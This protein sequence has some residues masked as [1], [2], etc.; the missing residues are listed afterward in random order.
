ML[1]VINKPL[2]LSVV[3][4]PFM[5]S[6]IMLNVIMLSSIMLSSIMLNVIM[7]SVIM[8]SVI[9][10]SVIMLSVRASKILLKCFS[11]IH[12]SMFIYPVF[13]NFIG[14]ITQISAFWL[15]WQMKT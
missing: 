6:V 8:L 4:K 5:P 7:L 2:M 11:V 3:S 14:V 15:Q 12:D 9:V 13:L 1:S 10:L